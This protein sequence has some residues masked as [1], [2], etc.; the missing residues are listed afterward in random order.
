MGRASRAMIAAQS[1][2]SGGRTSSRTPMAGVADERTWG[3]W[4]LLVLLSLVVAL[5]MIIGLVLH[6]ATTRYRPVLVDVF[7]FNT[8]LVLP[9]C[10]VLMPLAKRLTHQPRNLRFLESLSFGA[11]YAI[12]ALLL[13]AAFLPVAAARTTNASAII[14]QLKNSNVPGLAFGD[15]L[16]LLAAVQIYPG[17]NRLLGAPGRKARQRMLARNQGTT[18][19]P[20]GTSTKPTSARRR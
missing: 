14:D 15:L 7:Y 1:G 10:V 16:A 20:R 12:F 17:L 19:P 9:G 11:L 18:A 8:L 6:F 2:A 5:Q 13:T 3:R 4:G